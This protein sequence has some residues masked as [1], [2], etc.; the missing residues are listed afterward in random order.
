MQ[1]KQ[2]LNFDE[3]NVKVK[4]HGAFRITVF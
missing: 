2:M 4:I 1:G 3:C